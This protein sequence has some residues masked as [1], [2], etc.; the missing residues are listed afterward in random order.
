MKAIFLLLL[1]LALPLTASAQ[2]LSENDLVGKFSLIGNGGFLSYSLVFNKD[3]SAIL[4]QQ[5]ADGSMDCQGVFKFDVKIADL[6]AVFNC[7][8]GDVISQ[9]ISLA[10][11]TSDDLRNGVKVNVH[12]KSSLGSDSIVSM[13]LKGL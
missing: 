12:V 5:M 9:E 8:A 7:P 3:G 6:A 10:G 4:T 1:F 13:E 2:G 11:I